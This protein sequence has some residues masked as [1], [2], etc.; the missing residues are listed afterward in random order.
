MN[1]KAGD[2]A[3]IVGTVV[4]ENNGHIVEVLFRDPEGTIWDSEP[5]WVV[6]SAGR[7]LFGISQQTGEHVEVV[8]GSLA[9]RFLRPIS[10]VPVHDEQHDEVTA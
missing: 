2:L 9:D 4:P 8:V 5:R 1:V 7:K 3:Y 10:G 6:K